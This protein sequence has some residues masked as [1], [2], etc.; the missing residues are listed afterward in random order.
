[1]WSTWPSVDSSSYV[2][3]LLQSSHLNCSSWETSTL[4]RV[5][6]EH[7]YYWP[8]YNAQHTQTLL[9][10]IY[11]YPNITVTKWR[12][13]KQ[14]RDDA[15]GCDATCLAAVRNFYQVSC[16]TDKYEAGSHHSGW[17]CSNDS[18]QDQKQHTSQWTVLLHYYTTTIVFSS[19]FFS[20]I[21]C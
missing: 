1:M 5:Q 19:F 12:K 4:T 9:W 15:T 14:H 6:A 17:S 2:F 10:I 7:C 8:R 3:L 18:T 13:N 11:S 20:A 21:V 16:A